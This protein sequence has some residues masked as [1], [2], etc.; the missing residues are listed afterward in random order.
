MTSPPT[1]YQDKPQEDKTAS[2]EADKLEDTCTD[3]NLEFSDFVLND[4]SVLKVGS[5][6]FV[7]SCSSRN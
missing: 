2:G 6:C 7:D 3:M 4:G 5:I 1:S